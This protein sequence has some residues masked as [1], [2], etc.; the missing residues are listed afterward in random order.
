MKTKSE[1]N[2]RQTLALEYLA[3]E[4]F[5]KNKTYRELFDVSH[6]TA[7][8]ELVDLVNK[9]LIKSQGSGR[10]TCYV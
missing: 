10:S 6:K 1:L 9:N 4:N 5:I 8:L 2:E 3:E 7:H